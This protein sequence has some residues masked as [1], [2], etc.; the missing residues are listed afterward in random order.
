MVKYPDIPGFNTSP[1]RTSHSAHKSLAEAVLGITDRTNKDLAMEQARIAL[2]GEGPHSDDFSDEERHE[3]GLSSLIIEEML[4]PDRSSLSNVLID[5]PSYTR[6]MRE[7]GTRGDGSGT[8]LLIG[9]LTPLS[10][11]AHHVLAPDEFGIDT[12]LVVDPV[13]SKY[14]ARQGLIYASGLELPFADESMDFVITNQLLHMLRDP[15]SRRQSFRKNS[16]KLFGEIGRVL[17]PEGQVLMQE[18]PLGD[19]QKWSVRKHDRRT[20]KLAGFVYDS[21]N[22]NG[23]TTTAMHLQETFVTNDYLFDPNREFDGERYDLP[24]LT[25]HAQKRAKA[26]N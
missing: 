1:D 9:S 14:K 24:V 13:G 23:I 4:S 7:Y 12:T 10:S 3:L 22:R 16:K 8:A 17:K 18:P 21:L 6:L 5:W 26:Q 19:R 11:R 2:M 20:R 25:L 15:R